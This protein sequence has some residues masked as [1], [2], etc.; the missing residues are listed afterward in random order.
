MTDSSHRTR[1]SRFHDGIKGSPK[2][3]VRFWTPMHS[4]RL[5]WFYKKN[6]K[7]PGKK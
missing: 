4:F 6:T 2:I 5:R 7:G 1:L 3:N